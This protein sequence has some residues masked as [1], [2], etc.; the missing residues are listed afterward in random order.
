MCGLKCGSASVSKCHCGFRRDAEGS[1]W[2]SVDPWLVPS[3]PQTPSD[4][5]YS[6]PICLFPGHGHWDPGVPG[7]YWEQQDATCLGYW[8]EPHQGSGPCESSWFRSRWAT[9]VQV[10]CGHLCVV[11]QE[12]LYSI[13][14][15]FGPL[16]LLKVSSNAPQS[17]PG[18]SALVRFY[19]A[20]QAS[21]AQS[22]TD[23]QTL[24]QTSALKVALVIFLLFSTCMWTVAVWAE[25]HVH[26]LILML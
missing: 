10:S 24:F 7:P 17:P 16:Y 8:A 23:G 5:D 15:C 1:P 6:M 13:F 22:L 4:P 19:S 25:R 9:E 21:K 3:A 20:L 18:F 26:V 11:F 12:K 2:S 14:S